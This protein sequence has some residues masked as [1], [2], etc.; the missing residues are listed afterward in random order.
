MTEQ[1]DLH[2]RVRELE[3][4]VERWK[5]I[6]LDPKISLAASDGGVDIRVRHQMVAL[7]VDAFAG[8]LGDAP[9]YVTFEGHSRQHGI[10]RVT[11]QRS[12]G[13]SPHELATEYRERLEAMGVTD[14]APLPPRQTEHQPDPVGLPHLWIN[15]AKQRFECRTCGGSAPCPREATGEWWAAL[16]GAFKDI[17]AACLPAEGA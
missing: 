5:R 1:D 2:R 16:M 6:A 12:S 9:N 3:A 4:E 10:L 13:K 11:I 8:F 7:V 14:L 15:V 17:H